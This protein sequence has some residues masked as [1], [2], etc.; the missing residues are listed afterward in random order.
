MEG[1]HTVSFGVLCPE[2]CPQGTN[3]TAPK[4]GAPE[5]PGLRLTSK[6][7]PIVRHHQRLL[8]REAPQPTGADVTCGE[9]TLRGQMLLPSLTLGNGLSQGAP[10]A[11]SREG[12]VAPNPSGAGLPVGG[13]P[14]LPQSLR[15]LLAPHITISLPGGYTEKSSGWLGP[16][17]SLPAGPSQFSFWG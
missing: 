13:P 11:G 3:F 10:C 15:G 1:A 7:H 8:S 5:G 6:E 4:P 16:P 2:H 9:Q 14:V 17:E 12:S